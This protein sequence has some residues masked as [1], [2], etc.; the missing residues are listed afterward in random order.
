ME[1][2]RD[3]ERVILHYLP[4]WA[5]VF[6]PELVSMSSLA[7]EAYLDLQNCHMTMAVS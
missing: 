6:P 3:Q 2:L 5:P 4:C 7:T 1:I